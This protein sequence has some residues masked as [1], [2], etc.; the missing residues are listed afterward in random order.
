MTTVSSLR[1]TPSAPAVVGYVRTAAGQSPV[2]QINTLMRA[3][4]AEED[5][6]VERTNGH[7]AAW[8]ERDLL[9]PRLRSGD[10]ITMTRLD[11]LFYSVQNLIIVG[12]ELRDRSI[13]IHAVEQDIDSNTIQG[14]DFFGMMSVFASLHRDFV[15]AAT[16]DGLAAA[17]AQGRTGGRP[18]R[19]TPEQA[20][21]AQQLYDS[22]TPVPKIARTFKAAPATIYRYITPK[23]AN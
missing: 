1:R 17:R 11:R 14:R 9:L 13:R 5:I 7:K 6:Y 22:G 23:A 16:N 2:P 12:T 19:L 20:E 21:Q 3:G 4:V 10:T 18:P 15:L 8:P